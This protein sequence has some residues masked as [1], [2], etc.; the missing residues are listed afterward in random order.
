[1]YTQCPTCKTVFRVTPEQLAA[2]NGKVRCGRCMLVFE[3]QAHAVSLD[4]QNEPDSNQHHLPFNGPPPASRAEEELPASGRGIAPTWDDNSFEDTELDALL[5]ELEGSDEGDDAQADNDAESF[6]PTDHAIHISPYRESQPKQAIN[7]SEALSPTPESHPAYTETT[8]TPG[9]DQAETVAKRDE[10]PDAA[11]AAAGTA[12][13]VFSEMAATASEDEAIAAPPTTPDV[14]ETAAPGMP[15]HEAATEPTADVI[16]E[17]A[18]P[19]PEPDTAEDEERIWRFQAG[20]EPDEPDSLPTFST[21]QPAEIDE[22]DEPTEPFFIQAEEEDEF[23][24]ATSSEQTG[25]SFSALSDDDELAR[26]EGETSFIQREKERF[27]TEHPGWL[28]VSEAE[29]AEDEDL[30]SFSAG[31]ESEVDETFATAQPEGD[32]TFLAD[33]EPGEALS[34]DA[35]AASEAD[36]AVNDWDEGET[37]YALADHAYHEAL[38]EVS[39]QEAAFTENEPDATGVEDAEVEE[40]VALHPGEE[41]AAIE[42]LRHNLRGE[43]AAEHTELPPQLVQVAHEGSNLGKNLLWMLGILLMFALLPL[44]FM[45]HQRNLLA[46]SP[47]WRPWLEQICAVTGC[48]LPAKRDIS[49]FE[50]SGNTVQ[51]HPQ[52]ANSLL[53]T[54]TLVNNAAFTQPYPLVE[55]RMTDVQQRIVASRAFKPAEYLAGI[56]DLDKGIAPGHEAHLVLEVVDPGREAIGFEFHFH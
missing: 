29:A 45:H 1:M 44:Q 9:T 7:I 50:L 11:F 23:A 32:D 43:P 6:W 20:Q 52:H 10:S 2:A 14:V 55:L 31:R 24:E 49:A 22:E 25:E 46:E 47:K 39:P 53:I 18:Q 33:F 54:A 15:D 56:I 27:N 34:A 5:A 16:P 30:P 40:P 42:A 41:D 19:E 13:I 17:A 37:F 51:S 35:I 48:E 38:D 36:E 12:P 21:A 8:A 4:G 26:E 28:E 3:A